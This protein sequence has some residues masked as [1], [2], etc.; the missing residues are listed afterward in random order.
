MSR[1]SRDPGYRTL[2][3]VR[4]PRSRGCVL[5]G[6]RHHGGDCGELVAIEPPWKRAH[7]RSWPCYLQAH[8]PRF[9]ETHVATPPR[10]QGGQA[11]PDAQRLGKAGVVHAERGL[12]RFE[13]HEAAL[14][15][16]NLEPD[17]D[18]MFWQCREADAPLHIDEH[19]I[20][21]VSLLL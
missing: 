15:A 4:S 12:G 9:E 19:R 20:E 7:E 11:R 10:H 21:I 2:L 6:L 17:H 8:P 1:R 16:I 5:A 18:G 13:Q 14:A 3:S